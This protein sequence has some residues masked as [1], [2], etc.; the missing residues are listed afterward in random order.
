MKYMGQEVA[1]YAPWHDK[2]IKTK[3]KRYT[4]QVAMPIWWEAN[5]MFKPIMD[6]T[7]KE[8]ADE[9]EIVRAKVATDNAKAYEVEHE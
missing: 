6:W 2:I 5:T 8:L 9:H 7:D 1:E 3:S 4:C